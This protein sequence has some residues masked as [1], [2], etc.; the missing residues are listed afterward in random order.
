MTIRNKVRLFVGLTGIGFFFYAISA[1]WSAIFIVALPQDSDW[2]LETHT[3]QIGENE[4]E[5]RCIAFKNKAA[6]IKHI[7]NLRMVERNRYWIYLCVF[8][9]G[10]LGVIVLGR[11]NGIAEIDPGWPGSSAQFVLGCCMALV[12]P[13]LFSWL[14]PPPIDWFPEELVHIH[15]ARQVEALKTL[16]LPSS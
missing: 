1:V 15:D 10:I 9:G 13:L 7:Y 2:C 6:Q 12:G 11:M 5:E 4:Y 8:L 3:F 16:G 14:L